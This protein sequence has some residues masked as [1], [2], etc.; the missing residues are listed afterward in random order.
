MSWTISVRRFEKMS[1]APQNGF[2]CRLAASIPLA[3]LRVTNRAEYDAGLQARGSPT[4]WFTP[5]AIAVWKA[6]PHIDRAD[7]S[8][9]GWQR[10]S[11]HGWRALVESD[12]PRWK[13]V[14]GDGLRSQTDMCLP[15]QSSR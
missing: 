2:S 13:R 7:S 12:I 14:I 9:M 10:A 8:R 5:E 4:V 1:P 3:R 6:E 15:M 11:G